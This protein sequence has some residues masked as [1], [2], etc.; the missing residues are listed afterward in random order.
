MDDPMSHQPGTTLKPLVKLPKSGDACW[1]WIGRAS[2]D[3]YPVKQFGGR[4][5]PARRWIYTQLLGP[6]PD[7]LVVAS[8]CGNRACVNPL[9][10]Y[11]TF[12]AN[13]NRGGNNTVLTPADITE[14]R[15]Q[16]RTRTPDLA[17]L[18]ADRYGVTPATIRDVWRRRSHNAARKRTRCNPVHV[19]TTLAEPEG[20]AA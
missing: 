20:E 17:R 12:Q 8:R 10:L 7:G 14:I 15:A 11:V 3:G 2:V 18:L 13:A 5:I 9:H 1:E 4:A 19:P 6:I 16:G